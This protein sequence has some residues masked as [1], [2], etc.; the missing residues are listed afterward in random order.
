MGMA[1]LNG[2]R[3]GDGE[4]IGSPQGADEENI[5]TGIPHWVSSRGISARIPNGQALATLAKV[6]LARTKAWPCSCQGAALLMPKESALL[7]P[8]ELAKARPCSCQG[9]VLL[10]PKESARAHAKDRKCARAKAHP[11]SCQGPCQGT[12]VLPAKECAKELAKVQPCSRQ[13]MCQGAT[14]LP[15]RNA[16]RNVPRY[17]LP[18]PRRDLARA[19]GICLARA[20]GTCQGTTLLVPKEYARAHAKDHNCARAKAPLCSPPRNVPRSNRARAKA[21]AKAPLCSR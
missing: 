14:V 6:C 5:P 13:G 18:V 19:Q 1:N 10:V 21:C 16:L 3:D 2:Y 9:A 8:K 20:Q 12:A 15:P 4:E 17:A 11:C 7:E